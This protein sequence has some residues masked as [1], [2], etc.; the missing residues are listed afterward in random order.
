MAQ[1]E[2]FLDVLLIEEI[3]VEDAKSL[4]LIGLDG[5]AIETTDQTAQKPFLGRV[6]TCDKRFPMA[7]QWIDMPYK[8]G[9]IVY[10]NEFGR[11]YLRLDPFRDWKLIKKDDTKYYTIP[12]QD[13]IGKVGPDAS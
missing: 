4:D 13:I 10:A 3:P 1:L 9:D 12:Y 11:E 5:K 8:V 2:T 7:G 6:V